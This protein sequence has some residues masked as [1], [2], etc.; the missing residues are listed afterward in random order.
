MTTAPVLRVTDLVWKPGRDVLGPVSL[1]LC[2]RTCAA[3]IGPS[4]AGKTTLLRVIAGLDRALSGRVE[5]SAPRDDGRRAFGFVFQ[6]LFLWPHMTVLEN[7][8]S[9]YD[10]PRRA[11]RHRAGALLERLGIAS[12]AERRPRTLSGGE[13]QRVAIG[14]AIIGEPSVLVLDEPLTGLDRKVRGDLIELLTGLKSDGVAMLLA[15]HDDAIVDELADTRHLL[16]QGR[17]TATDP[18][19]AE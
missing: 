4:G 15:T 7:V 16:R 9:G 11:A 17:L 1:S 5:V 2:D 18:C 10:A 13:A 8:A 14:R 6:G 19:A 12:L 3:I